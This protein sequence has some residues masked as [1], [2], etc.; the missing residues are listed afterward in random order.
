[1]IENG[2]EDMMSTW[3]SYVKDLIKELEVVQRGGLHAYKFGLYVLTKTPY[4]LVL[5]M[6]VD[7]VIE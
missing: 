7:I 1:M 2:D 6:V 5:E 4:S 3:K